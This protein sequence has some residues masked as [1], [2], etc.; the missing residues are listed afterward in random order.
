MLKAIYKTDG[1]EII[2]YDIQ[3]PQKNDRI[4]IL[5][6]D[7]SITQ[8]EIEV[9]FP[10]QKRIDVIMVFK[11]KYGSLPIN[12][13]MF[14]AYPI[15]NASLIANFPNGYKFRLFQSLSTDLKMSLNENTRHIYEAQGGI[16]PLQ[17]F[18]FYLDRS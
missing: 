9:P 6:I 10:P 2:Y 15:I 12:D 3:N 5:K 1:K 4:D 11:V 16:L 7:D 17:G 18:I 13:S 14:T 8:L